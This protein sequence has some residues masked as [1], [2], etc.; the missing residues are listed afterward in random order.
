MS[1]VNFLASVWE[2]SPAVAILFAFALFIIVLSRQGIIN[3]KVRGESDGI[4]RISALEDISKRQSLV[5]AEM[6]ED[7]KRLSNQIAKLSTEIAVMRAVMQERS[8]K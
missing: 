6:K 8:G 2:A 3:F 1:E 5:D 7:L 4:S